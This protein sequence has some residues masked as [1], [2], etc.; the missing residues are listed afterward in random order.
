MSEQIGESKQQ[1]PEEHFDI[2]QF[3]KSDELLVEL[4]WSIEHAVRELKVTFP[5]QDMGQ[6]LEVA[7]ILGELGASVLQIAVKKLILE[8]VGNGGE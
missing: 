3:P 5:M 2:S 7:R 1:P 4:N 8:Q 6:Q